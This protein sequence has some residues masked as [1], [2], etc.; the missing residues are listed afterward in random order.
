[1]KHAKTYDKVSWHFPEGKNC[2]SLDSAK[3]HFCVVMKWLQENGLLSDE[4]AEAID[5]GIDADFSITARM[6]TPRGNR[7]LEQCYES[8]LK[9]VQ[10]GEQPVTQLL[11]EHLRHDVM[12]G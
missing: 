4:G 10:Y 8:W 11:D 9:A 3:I 7:V 2:P 5:C 12:N 1:M 6:L